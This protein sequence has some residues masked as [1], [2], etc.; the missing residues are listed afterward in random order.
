[1]QF[2]ATVIPKTPLIGMVISIVCYMQNH[3]PTTRQS[4]KTK[5][6]RMT[7]VERIVHVYVSIIRNKRER[8]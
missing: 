3:Y 6:E 1:M 4:G 2:R 7:R 8:L 5:L